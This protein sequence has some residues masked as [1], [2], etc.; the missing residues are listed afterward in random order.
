MKYIKLFISI[1]LFLT[2]SCEEYKNPM[3]EFE[4]GLGNDYQIYQK[5]LIEKFHDTEYY[6]IL[7]DSTEFIEISNHQISSMK[8]RIPELSDETLDKYFLKNNY[9]RKLN[10]I[11]NIDFY[12]F[13]SDYQYDKENTVLVWLSEI[14]YNASE[15]QAIVAMGSIYAALVGE[16]IIFFL[17]YENGRWEIKNEYP[18]WIA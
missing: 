15:T 4:Y 6:V 7:K 8:D 1:I 5:I 18:L 16:G 13:D 14:G 17:K 9:S 2:F 11:S 3:H 10:N 12:I